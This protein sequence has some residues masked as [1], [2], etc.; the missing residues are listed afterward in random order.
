MG[1][2]GSAA[3]FEPVAIEGFGDHPELHV[4]GHD[5][6]AVLKR[7][8]RN[9]RIS[10]VITESGAQ[11]GPTSRYLQINARN[12]FAVE[13]QHRSLDDRGFCQLFTSVQYTRC[14]S[15]VPQWLR[16]TGDR[17]S[18]EEARSNGERR[19]NTDRRSGLDRRSNNPAG[20]SPKPTRSLEILGSTQVG[21]LRAIFVR[22]VK[23]SRLAEP[24]RYVQSPSRISQLFNAIV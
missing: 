8:C 12:R 22:G 23:Q 2:D 17:V 7:R 20:P 14:L 24:W 3:T 5:S 10:A 13:S 9:H 15:G 21:N 4:A 19:S 16:I 11:L 1:E 6:E 18:R